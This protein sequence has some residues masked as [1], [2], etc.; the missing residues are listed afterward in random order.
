MSQGNLIPEL[1]YMEKN[2]SCLKLSRG[3]NRRIHLCYGFWDF[4]SENF[5][6]FHLIT[7]VPHTT[8]YF[9]RVVLKFPREHWYIMLN[10]GTDI[11]LRNIN[12]MCDLCQITVF[13]VLC[14]CF[15][16]CFFVIG[17]VL[18]CLYIVVVNLLKAGPPLFTLYMNEP[19]F[20]FKTAQHWAVQMKSSCMPLVSSRSQFAFNVKKFILCVME[21]LCSHAAA[22][23]LKSWVF[24]LGYFK[25]PQ[26]ISDRNIV[27]FLL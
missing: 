26:N 24:F 23:T 19:I 16:F 5:A 20:I 8:H 14:V 13:V 18:S 22:T 25:I 3:N 9:Y 15:F 7:F 4:F 17:K 27:Y 12:K 6:F 11:C 2:Q 10:E 21:M 1:R